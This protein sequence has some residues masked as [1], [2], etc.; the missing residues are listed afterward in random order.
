MKIMIKIS[1]QLPIIARPV[2]GRL[3][4]A[5]ICDRGKSGES[6]QNIW[7]V[8]FMNLL[9]TGDFGDFMKTAS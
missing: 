9:A 2:H 6:H 7:S 1:I 3:G 8:R 4:I 5:S